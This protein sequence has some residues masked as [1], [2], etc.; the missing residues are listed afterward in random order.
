[1]VSTQ[2]G[3]E[4]GWF[5]MLIFHFLHC[6]VHVTP[7]LEDI[8]THTQVR[9]GYVDKEV[10]CRK[11]KFRIYISTQVPP[12]KVRFCMLIFGS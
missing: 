8:P 10:N 6:I 7:K 12:E 2:V 9:R 1:M 3:L 11:L 5:C 4:K